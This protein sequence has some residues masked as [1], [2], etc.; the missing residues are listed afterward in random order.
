MRI[1][2]LTVKHKLDVCELKNSLFVFMQTK[3]SRINHACDLPLQKRKTE[4]LLGPF[5]WKMD[6]YDRHYRSL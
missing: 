6:N 5:V 3:V 4:I 2:T 1:G